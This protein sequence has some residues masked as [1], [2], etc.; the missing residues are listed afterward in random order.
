[1]CSNNKQFSTIFSLLSKKKHLVYVFISAKVMRKLN[2]IAGLLKLK[3]NLPKE[4]YQMVQISDSGI[5]SGAKM[6]DM[7][8]GAVLW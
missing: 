7:Y 1:M 2:S 8:S 5:T 3:Y 6:A 4:N